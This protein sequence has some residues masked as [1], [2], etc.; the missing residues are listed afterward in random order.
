M[1]SKKVLIEIGVIDKNVSPSLSKAKKGV[2]ELA[3]ST[4]RLT[5]SNKGNRAQ[6]GLNNAILIET[7]R[8]ASDASYGIQGMANNIGRIIELGQEFAR[9]NK[10]GMGAA[11]QDLRKSLFGVGGVLI[12]VQ[13]LLSF[14]P[15]IVKKF[16][17]VSDGTSD[18]SAAVKNLRKDFFDLKEEIK[19]SN[20]ALV[21]QDDTI[22]TL[23]GRLRLAVKANL[24]F[25]LFGN[26][27]FIDKTLER[28]KAL[29]VEI[30]KNKL[31]SFEH[32]PEGLNEFIDQL[33]S[34]SGKIDKVTQEVVDFGTDLAVQRILGKKTPVEL[35]EMALQVFIKEQEALG[36]KEE[37][38]IKS[39]E[40]QILLAKIEAAKIEARRKAKEDAEKNAPEKDYEEL[41]VRSLRREIEAIKELGK[42]R[43]AFHKKNM[44]LLVQEQEFAAGAIEMERQQRIAEI[45]ATTNDEIKKRAAL[46]EVN[47]YYDQLMIREKREALLDL[48]QAII[49]ASGQQSA[50]GKA[51]AIAMALF[52]TYEGITAA[53]KIAPPLG[54]IYAVTRGLMGFAQ[55]RNIMKIDP[56][57]PKVPSSGGGASGGAGGGLQAPEF[58]VVGASATNQ[59]AM[60]VGESGLGQPIRA[61]VV[62]KDITNQQ[63][64]DNNQTNIA[65]TGGG[66]RTGN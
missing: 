5:K 17:E 22:K 16:K 58:N 8:V 49:E 48:G 45:D 57:N 6:S 3:A 56:N 13:L 28:L 51:T 65:G 36:V 21:D 12:G 26:T 40:Y 31:L 43:S 44:G 54:E 15:R 20:E 32:D 10:G 7:G 47:A 11:L 42:I 50:V 24:P 4:D 39:R 29:G 41:P 30:D 2:D 18:L 1:A 27:D 64:F 25:R 61:Y 53:L 35:A 63:E 9:T 19:E 38:Y 34:S 52:N 37:E 33:L 23:L 46:R 59:L 62:G 60:A 14:L 66:R 55:V